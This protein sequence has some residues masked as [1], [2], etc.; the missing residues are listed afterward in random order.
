[1]DIVAHHAD[2]SEQARNLRFDFANT[3]AVGVCTH[4]DYIE[5]GT[6][7]EEEEASMTQDAIISHAEA[8]GE[9]KAGFSIWM[10]PMSAMKI[11]SVL[12]V[13][14][15]LGGRKELVE[16]CIAPVPPHLIPMPWQKG[17]EGHRVP[18][19]G[20]GAGGISEIRLP[21]AGR[22]LSAHPLARRCKHLKRLRLKGWSLSG[23]A[24]R[25]KNCPTSC[26]VRNENGR[27]K[28]EEQSAYTRAPCRRQRGL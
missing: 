28:D 3:G 15:R 11:S 1:M 19:S 5:P 4:Y 18:S 2:S 27:T 13:W 12:E 9:L 24:W 17:L 14:L 25:R 22:H 8:S 7:K 16:L 6:S 23:C 10:K 21:P 20:G 26:N